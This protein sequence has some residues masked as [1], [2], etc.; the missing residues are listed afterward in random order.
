MKNA[1]SAAALAA[2]VLSC[3]GLVRAQA[4]PDVAPPGAVAIHPVIGGALT[5][6]GDKLLAVRYTDGDTRTLRAGQLAQVWAGIDVR[7]V[8]SP[9]SFLA[10]VGY[11]SDSAGGWNGSVRFERFPIEASVL[12]SP[13]PAIRIGAGARYAA[14][15]AVRS[16]GVVDDIPNPHFKSRLGG[17]VL[18]E[19]LVTPHQGVQLRYVHETYRLS[20][21]SIDGSHGGIGYSFYF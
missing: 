12:W 20:G 18:A 14:G 9:V 2:L 3:P 5:A 16:T 7:P 4:A 10:T 8:D 17:L 6:G 21:R 11:H 19:W 1:L 13:A 15:A